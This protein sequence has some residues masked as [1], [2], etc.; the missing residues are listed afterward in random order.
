M[1][2]E[3]FVWVLDRTKDMINHGGTKIFSAELEELL[4]RHPAVED[5]AVVGVPDRVAGEA[6][7]AFLVLRAPLTPAE[8]RAWV[9]AGMAD[10]A[11]PKVVEVLDA[12]PRGATGKTDKQSLRAR[13]AKDVE[14]RLVP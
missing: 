7:A 5:A 4:R 10:Y 12:L 14:G 8:V 11:A 2:A 9:R 1:D 13:L 3:G 6:V